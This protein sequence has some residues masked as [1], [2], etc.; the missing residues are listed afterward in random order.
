MVNS[1]VQLVGHILLFSGRKKLLFQTFSR[2]NLISVS[3]YK[4]IVSLLLHKG[5]TT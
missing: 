2:K 5:S 3:R 1:Q 4:K